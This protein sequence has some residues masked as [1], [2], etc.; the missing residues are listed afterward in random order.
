MSA[1]SRA[2]D[3]RADPRRQNELHRKAAEETRL[4]RERNL[5]LDATV[6]ELRAELEQAKRDLEVARAASPVLIRPVS[7]VLQPETALVF[8]HDTYSHREPASDFAPAE[9]ID[10]C[11]I[12]VDH[13]G[14]PPIQ[15]DTFTLYAEADAPLRPNLFAP[16]PVHYPSMGLAFPGVSAGS[17]PA[18][19]YSPESAVDD[20]PPMC[21]HC[22]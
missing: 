15:Y 20:L 6:A 3:V 9:L 11:A 4:Y 13:L 1:V 2:L 14:P 22:F 10:P 19:T 8:G 12:S 21:V 17:L 18:L 7:P 5:N 16:T